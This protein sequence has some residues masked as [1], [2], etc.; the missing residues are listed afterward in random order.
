MD[1]FYTTGL[2]PAPHGLCT[3]KPACVGTQLVPRLQLLNGFEGVPQKPVLRFTILSR[4]ALSTA[5]RF[6]KHNCLRMP[7]WTSNC[8]PSW[9][10]FRF[11]NRTCY[12]HASVGIELQTVLGRCV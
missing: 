9:A 7:L 4:S 8:R 6:S 10:A 5:F 12:E 2:Q 1:T 11:C 3:I